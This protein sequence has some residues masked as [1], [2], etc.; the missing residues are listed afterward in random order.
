MKKDKCDKCDGHRNGNVEEATYKKHIENK[1]RA[2][3]KEQDK[4]KALKNECTVLA[5]DL[6]AVKLAPFINC[7]GY[8]YK[9]KLC[10]HNFTIYNL[11]THHVRCYWFTECDADLSA[12]TYATCVIDFLEECCGHEHHKIIIYSDGCTDAA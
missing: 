7:S 10:C 11:S 4:E 9:T 12:S 8:Y 6:Q 2:R 1:N 5:M 3:E